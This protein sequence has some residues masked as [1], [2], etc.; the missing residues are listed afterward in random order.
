MMKKNAPSVVFLALALLLCACL[1]TDV[2]PL[3]HARGKLL[4]LVGES[5]HEDV[6]IGKNGF[7]F[8][9]EALDKPL[10]T[11]GDIARAADA[12]LA[13]SDALKARGK[14]FILLIAPDKC[15]VY[16]QQLPQRWASAGRNDSAQRLYLALDARGVSYVDVL[17]ALQSADAPTYL[18]TDTHWNARGA[19][20][21]YQCLMNAL[22]LPPLSVSQWNEQIITG[23]LHHMAYPLDK[24]SEAAPAPVLARGYRFVKPMRSLNDFDIRTSAQTKTPRALVV[25]DSFGEALFDY[26]ANTFSELTYLRAADGLLDK[27]Q[28]ADIVVLEIAER[29]LSELCGMTFD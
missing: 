15:A 14:R 9:W 3:A 21:A 20:I 27:C 17:P 11:D 6:I 28:S 8:Y 12:L 2:K 26:F 19:Y 18:R 10:L 16:P 4:S 24:G 5:G 23:D 29:R 13:L 22:N 7:L 1:L 25:R